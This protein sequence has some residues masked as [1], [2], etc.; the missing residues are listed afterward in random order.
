MISIFTGSTTTGGGSSLSSGTSSGSS[1]SSH[2]LKTG[3]SRGLQSSESCKS[4]FI[5]IQEGL[6]INSSP[7][8]VQFC[9]SGHLLPVT[10]SGPEVLITLS[11]AAD[12][13]LFDSRVELNVDIQLIKI[14]DSE[15]GGTK[16]F[17]KTNLC[18]FTFDGVGTRYGVISTPT[19]SLPSNTTC[20]YKFSSLLPD[21]KV[22][23]YFSSYYVQDLHEWGSDEHCDVTSLEMFRVQ[24]VEIAHPSTRKK[25]CNQTSSTP[26]TLTQPFSQSSPILLSSSSVPIKETH[27]KFCEKSSPLVCGRSS[28]FDN[29]LP[30]SRPC[31]YPTE[32]YLSAGP[33]LIIKH[34]HLRQTAGLLPGLGSTFTAR[35]EF[36]DTRETGDPVEGTL[37]DRW[38][39]SHKNQRGIISSTRNTFL[40]GRGGRDSLS[41]SLHFVS[42]KSERLRLH[43]TSL[44]LDSSHCKTFSDPKSGAHSCQMSTTSNRNSS[45]NS[46]NNK[47]D[48]LIS[49]AVEKVGMLTIV[50]TI[51]SEQINVGCFCSGNGKGKIVSRRRRQEDV[52]NFMTTSVRDGDDSGNDHGNR[53]WD[54]IL[55]SQEQHKWLATFDLSGSEVILNLTITGMTAYDDFSNFFYEGRYEFLPESEVSSSNALDSYPTDY[56]FYLSTSAIIAVIVIGAVVASVFAVKFIQRR[57]RTPKSSPGIGDTPPHHR[58]IFSRRTLRTLT[59][60]DLPF[61]FEGSVDRR[62][63]LAA[64]WSTNGR[65]TF[66]TAYL[67][68]PG[69]LSIGMPRTSME[70]AFLPCSEREFDYRGFQRKDNFDCKS[71][72]MT[73]EINTH[74]L[75]QERA[76]PLIETQTLRYDSS[77]HTRLDRENITTL[78]RPSPY[79]TSTLNTRCGPKASVSSATPP[80][81]ST[82]SSSS[83]SSSHN[84][85]VHNVPPPSCRPPVPPPPPPPNPY[86]TAY[87]DDDDGG[88]TPFQSSFVTYHFPRNVF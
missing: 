43:I 80:T 20:T 15:L 74:Q 37:C 4:D 2:A 83:T 65:S 52:D 60:V 12:S 29:L 23:I 79:A 18:D 35:F 47:Q 34:H 10:S 56:R 9:G 13:V 30:P 61:S 69:G 44:R 41:C 49:P 42:K 84:Q 40:F 62:N 25:N 33:E 8:L 86:T 54:G 64:P 82:S 57:K 48:D 70:Q 77:R 75:H 22:W 51:K 38:I 6:D 66:T 76:T 88:T 59:G 50:D 87:E 36:I 3:S 55:S 27:L 71:R 26:P 14:P 24:S 1:S 19:F 16:S 17:E 31:L 85:M 28:D 78:K 39:F 5:R 68:R 21:D 7:T 73:K 46:V 45:T 32:S 53:N 81:I 63:G 58:D 67:T 72:G 11:S